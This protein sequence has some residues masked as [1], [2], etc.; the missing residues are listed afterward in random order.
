MASDRSVSIAAVRWCRDN[1]GIVE[2]WFDRHSV[3]VE[4]DLDEDML[5]D[6]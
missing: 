6:E 1:V 5:D 2:A 3:Q 4:V